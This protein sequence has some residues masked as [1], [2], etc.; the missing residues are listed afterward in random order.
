MLR[1]DDF[2]TGTTLGRY[3]IVKQL[4]V[5]GMAEI[6][7]ARVR[8]TA[9]FEKL[10]VLKRISP[11][12]ADDQEFV[13]MFLDEARL[14]ATLRHPNIADVFDIGTE[15]GCYYF[16]MEFIHG[17]DARSVRLEA[18]EHHR[19]IPLEVSLGIVS[20]TAYALAYAHAKE[21]PNGPLGI[22]HRDISPTNILISYDGAVKLVDFGIARADS[23]I[24]EKTHMLES[25][26]PYMSPEQCRGHALDRRSD[27]FSLGT[28]FYE[29]TCGEHPFD[30]RSEHA[31]VEMIATGPLRRPT[32]HVPGYPPALEQIVMRMLAREPAARYQTAD[33][34]L[35]DLE[36]FV[37]NAGMM[38]SERVVAKYMREL[39]AAELS[40]GERDPVTVRGEDALVVTPGNDPR[41][42][43][44]TVPLPF[45]QASSDPPTAE[46]RVEDIL[47]EP[48]QA[49]LIMPEVQV[50]VRR[51]GSTAPPPVGR[52]ERAPSPVPRAASP[53]PTPPSPPKTRPAHWPRVPM[54]DR[55][56]V[57]G[58]GPVT[59]PD[60]HDESP[61]V[62]PEDMTIRTRPTGPPDF[63]DEQPTEQM[64]RSTALRSL[65]EVTRRAVPRDT[66]LDGVLQFDPVLARGDDILDDIDRDAPSKETAPA[67]A[68]RRIR[69]L[70]ARIR[71]W[72]ELGDVDQAVVGAELVFEENVSSGVAK[73][74]FGAEHATLTAAFE[75]FLGDLER[76]PLRGRPLEELL[77]LDLDPLANHLLSQI[78]GLRTLDELLEGGGMSRLEA[79]RWLCRL[80]LR[81]LIILA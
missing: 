36:R 57:T 80:A 41:P 78:D 7:L 31:T 32:E 44:A 4:A 79:S 24:S 30:R 26:V 37:S 28:V 69:E 56:R 70:G 9:G 8:A 64:S 27:I 25:K 51:S 11:P 33:D 20:G 10:V 22:V 13:Q 68:V 3:E 45:G 72:L 55:T 6:Y 47:E 17:Q 61:T 65:P 81:K 48:M 67:R 76:R 15:D 49:L 71:G 21:G 1:A 59:L 16:A 12:V 18:K 43:S 19:L 77:R 40:E 50:F 62:G 75:R 52:P 5:G 60:F 63:I 38:M 73:R 58:A 35:A 46:V 23:G 42:G 74:A 54:P 34:V 14:A 29:L 66:M 2:Q 53:A 39:F